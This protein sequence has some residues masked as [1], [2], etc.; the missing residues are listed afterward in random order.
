MKQI[1]VI[2]HGQTSWNAEGRW[3][4][5]ADVPLSPEGVAQAQTLAK[6]LSGVDFAMVYSSDLERAR[7]TGH[8]LA[9]AT[10]APLILDSRLRELNLG[11]LQGLTHAEIH[12]RYPDDVDQMKVN[13]L[14]H[15]VTR[16]ESR[17]ALQARAYAAWQDIL[18]QTSARPVALVSHGGTIRLLLLRLLDPAQRDA[19]MCME[20]GNTSWT[21]LNVD[22]DGSVRMQVAADS[23]H[24]E[25][26]ANDE[27]EARL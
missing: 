4:G 23:S 3:Q 22:E 12:E 5:H 11:A 15:V 26:H 6:H 7:E 27:G 21:V 16:G 18:E 1:Y 24:L 13:Y 14:D 19:I 25:R 17:R 10:G 8:A 2:R 20:I 9:R